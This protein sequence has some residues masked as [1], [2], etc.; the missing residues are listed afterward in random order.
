MIYLFTGSDTN[1]VRAKAFQWIAASR[2]K[3]PDA[4]YVRLNA[5][6]LSEPALREAL[7]AQGLFFSK[8]LIA[9]DDPFSTSESAELVLGMLS[10]LAASQNIV[11]IIAPKLLAARRKKVEAVAEKVF[12]IDAVAKAA[13]GF[14]AA[15]VNALSA[16]DGKALWKE[17]VT[18]YRAGDVPEMVHGLLHWKARDMMVKGGRNW[19]PEEARKLSRDL[20]ILLSDSRGKDVP[21]D[22]ALERFA[23]SLS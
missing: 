8:S 3:A 21:L 12:A 5:D 4:Y 18:A 20:I 9:L 19:S 17:I 23:L 10:E 15:L 7:G 22:L 13:R 16:K 11:A 2:A 14:N 6:T 1:R